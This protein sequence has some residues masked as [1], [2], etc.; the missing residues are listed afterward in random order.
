MLCMWA[1]DGREGGV[2]VLLPGNALHDLPGT[3]KSPSRLSDSVKVNHL[4]E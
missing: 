2:A 3:D 4:E 1:A